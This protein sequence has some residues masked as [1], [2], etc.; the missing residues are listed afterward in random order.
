MAYWIVKKLD[1]E[2]IIY[3]SG[4]D[5]NGNPVHTEDKA[6]AF[7]F[8]DLSIPMALYFSLGYCIEKCY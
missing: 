7:K 4:L 2:N 1:N 6:N 3:V 5:E 8:H